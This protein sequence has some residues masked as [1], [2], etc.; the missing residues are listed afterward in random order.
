MVSQNLKA[1]LG[2][3]GWQFCL[4]LGLYTAAAPRGT[5]LSLNKGSG[6]AAK[7]GGVLELTP[8]ALQKPE[9]QKVYVT[10]TSIGIGKY[11]HIHTGVICT[12]A[13]TTTSDSL[14]KAA[15]QQRHMK[16]IKAQL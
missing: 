12:E 5:V 4:S 13:C 7:I 8:S 15:V 6:K 3:S 11:S 10:D 2:D 1:S 16:P 14:Y 9:K